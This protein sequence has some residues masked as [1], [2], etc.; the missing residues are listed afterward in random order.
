MRGLR[1]ERRFHPWKGRVLAIGATT[2]FIYFEHVRFVVERLLNFV[3]QL[4]AVRTLV[5]SEHTTDTPRSICND[6]NAPVTGRTL[7]EHMRDSG[8]EPESE[9]WQRPVLPLDQPRAG[10]GEGFAPSSRP[11]QGR[12]LTIRLAATQRIPV[13]ISQGPPMCVVGLMLTR[14][15]E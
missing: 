6:C 7:F 13:G 9:R 15:P 3:E 14:F 10:P 8:V 12:I 11:S 4:R 2:R 1:V 5:S